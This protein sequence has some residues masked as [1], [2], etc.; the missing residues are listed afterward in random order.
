MSSTTSN[1]GSDGR[2][3]SAIVK[4]QQ[5]VAC[6]ADTDGVTDTVGIG[7]STVTL[8]VTLIVATYGAVADGVGDSDI[9]GVS[10]SD[11][12]G[13]SLCVGDGV[14]DSDIDSVTEAVVVGQQS[15]SPQ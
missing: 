8:G 3:R 9:D 10:D 14:D 15:H 2:S 5:Q 13:V 7:A 6:V 11:I 1:A 4:S 12:D